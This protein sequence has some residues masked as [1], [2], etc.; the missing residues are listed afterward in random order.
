M[1]RQEDEKG[2]IKT[3]LNFFGWYKT[4]GKDLYI[5]QGKRAQNLPAATA[6]R[7]STLL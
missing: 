1:L 7:F 6:S 4:E 3:F 2:R 5:F